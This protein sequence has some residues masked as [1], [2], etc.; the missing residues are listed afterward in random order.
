MT[1]INIANL[2]HK[3][4]PFLVGSPTCPAKIKDEMDT[5]FEESLRPLKGNYIFDAG[6]WILKLERT[7]GSKTTPDT[8]LYRVRKAEKI[9]TYIQK[10]NLEAHIAVPKKYLYWNTSQNQ[11]YVVA[12]KMD[13]STEVATPAS[14]DIE[15]NWR[16]AASYGG[17]VHALANKA[18]RR[19][20]TTIQARTLA[21]LSVLGYTDLSYNNL[22]FTK[23]GKVAVV[24]TE[25]QKRSLKKIVKSSF[26]FFLFGDKRSVLAQQSIAGIAKLKLYTDDPTALQAIE[27]VEKNHALWGMA[28]LIT[29]ISLVTLAIYFTPTITALI[30]IAIVATTLKVSFIAFAVLKNIF[31]ALNLLSVYIVWNFSCNGLKGIRQILN[32]EAQSLF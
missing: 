18:P 21:E 31:F 2:S 30:P 20:L 8:H 17:Q 11:F 6:K 27:K 24:D 14:K 29:K 16:G 25:P 32:M 7:D 28:R 23:D 1:N 15:E 26:F 13:L 19:S 4:Q 10:N 22:Y 12:E 9:R 3:F 5:I